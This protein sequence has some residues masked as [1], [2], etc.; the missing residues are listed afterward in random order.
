LTED[1]EG[2]NGLRILAT[3]S[4]LYEAEMDLGRWRD[5]ESNRVDH[6]IDRLVGALPSV[7]EHKCMMGER[8]GFVKEMR[9]G[10]NLAH[11]V[12]H[13]LLELLHLA[14]P[15]GRIYTGWTTPRR[16]A[17]GRLDT[18]VFVIHYQVNSTRQ[19]RLA[20]ECAVQLVTDLLAALAPDTQ[21][22]ILRLK[23]SFAWSES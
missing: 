15:E 20:V 18:G 23:E 12:E 10:T 16:A 9:D 8:G 5:I 19:A 14:D 13:V 17:D 7:W 2:A 22:C 21:G 4:S 1:H 3:R 6:F 11:V